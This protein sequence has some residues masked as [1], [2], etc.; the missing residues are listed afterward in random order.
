MLPFPLRGGTY[1]ATHV[2]AA[3]VASHCAVRA[4][5]IYILHFV[6]IIIRAQTCSLSMPQHAVETYG[7]PQRAL[8]R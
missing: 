2:I 8:A 6:S 1:L 7:G 3:K 4:R 5:L